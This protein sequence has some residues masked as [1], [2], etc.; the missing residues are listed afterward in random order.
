MAQEK[1]RRRT[2]W[3]TVGLLALCYGIWALATT[4]LAQVWLPAGI[5][6]AA[7]AITLFSSLQHEVLHGHPFA[8]RAVNE[9]LVF[10]GL[11]LFIPYRRFRDLHLAH[12]VDARL[13]DPFDDP[14]SNYLD[15]GLWE[16]LPA[17]S[18][19]LRR[20]NNTLLGRMLV[21]PALSQIAFMKDDLRLIRDGRKDVLWGWIWH[22]PALIVVGL[23][24]AHVG[25][26]PVWAYVLAAYLGLSVL[27]IRTFLEHR[28]HEHTGARTVIIEDRGPLALLFLNNNFHV[29]HHMHPRVP[30]YELPER[31]ARDRMRYL[32]RNDGYYYR[33]Y[34]AVF[35]RFLLKPKDPVAHPIWRRS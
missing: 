3:P 4:L 31:F 14:E 24:L 32:S 15:P 33:N 5:V 16:S 11:S 12:H 25:A 29:V 22:V 1:G 30:W 9:A 28:A 21:G 17:W 23:W 35:A 7:L 8:S 19:R 26:M 20:F 6:L 27:K 34:M 2:E 10:P 13:T 18:K